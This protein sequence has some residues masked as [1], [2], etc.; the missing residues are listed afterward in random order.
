MLCRVPVFLD[1][2]TNETDNNKNLYTGELIRRQT[3]TT[4][5]TNV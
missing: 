5:Y 1:Y 3:T 4:I 2:E